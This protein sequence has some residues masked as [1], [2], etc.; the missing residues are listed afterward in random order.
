[1][2]VVADIGDSMFGAIDLN[3]HARGVFISPP[4]YTSMVF[5]IPGALG[6][7]VAK[8][9]HRPIVLVGDGAFQ[10]S[11]TEL[12]TIVSRG[13][14][15]IVFVLNNHGYTTERFLLDGP[16]NDIANW[17]YHRITE[18]IGGGI[19]YS[20]STEGELETAI[21]NA[22]SSDKLNIISVE[23]GSKDISPA[24]LRMTDGLAKRV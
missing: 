4:F 22:L 23:L 21:H 10:M 16:F 14:N 15:P 19:G 12:S 5:A 24:L 20:V 3:V 11:C 2:V 17:N 7:Q 6:V 18:M 13:L 8:P 1:M 9:N